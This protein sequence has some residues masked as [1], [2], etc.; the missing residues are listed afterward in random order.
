[1]ALVIYI[2]A[3]IDNKTVV[4]LLAKPSHLSE[5]NCTIRLRSILVAKDHWEKIT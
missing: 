3:R 2:I 5:Y 4:L 1:M